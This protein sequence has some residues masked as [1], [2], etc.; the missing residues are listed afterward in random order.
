MDGYGRRY[1]RIAGELRAAILAGKHRPGARI[2]SENELAARY[3]VSRQ[4]VRKALAAL[5]EQGYVYI[6]ETPLYELTVKDQSYFA[7]DDREKD[8]L[9]KKLAV[10]KVS[11][12]RSKGLGEN[13]PEMMWQ[14]TMN[15][16]TRRLIKILPEEAEATAQMFDV[17]LGDNLSG[18]KDFIAVNG[19]KYL[20][21]LDI[22]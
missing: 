1:E 13:E 22:S 21:L 11:I 6:A 17:L 18:R 19:A 7:Y 15:P 3:Q 14:T 5:I 16:E 12:M 10:K 4:T 9:L 2:E 20:D 8:E